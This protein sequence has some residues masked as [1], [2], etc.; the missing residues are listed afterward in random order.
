VDDR[1]RGVHPEPFGNFRV[2]S[3]EWGRD[4]MTSVGSLQNYRL[5]ARG[6]IGRGDTGTHQALCGDVRVAPTGRDGASRNPSPGL[7][8]SESDVVA[9]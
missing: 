1:A 8:V 6:D 3:A 4:D 9:C 2:N 5:T 7:A